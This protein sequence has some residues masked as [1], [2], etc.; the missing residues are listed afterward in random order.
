MRVLVAVDGSSGSAEAVRQAGLLSSPDKD[1]LA[2]Y[3][4]PV[5]VNFKK[6]GLDAGLVGKARGSLAEAIF[7]EAR[8]QLPEPWRAKAETIVGDEPARQGVLHAAQTW[9]ADLI[10][11]GARGLGPIKRMMLG[12]VSRSVTQSATVPVLVAKKTPHKASGFRVLIPAEDCH[13]ARQFTTV[14]EQITWPQDTSGTLLS[15]VQPMH[16][17]EIPDWLEQRAR[18]PEIKHMAE[19]WANEHQQELQ[20]KRREMQESCDSLPWPWKTQEPV[21]LEGQPAEQ[22]LEAITARNIDLLVI[23]ARGTNPLTRL[24]LGSTT[25]VVVAHAPCSVL[26]VRQ[27]G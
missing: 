3:Y 14:L 15:V 20:A 10:V 12:S 13:H 4:S 21:I 25:A 24:L 27:K 5:A 19:A 11:V 9:K 18:D 23:G 6:S 8:P 7:G 2:L 26:I 1:Q 16:A 17:G 22:I